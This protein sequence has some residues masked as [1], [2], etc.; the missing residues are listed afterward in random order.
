MIRTS[1]LWVTALFSLCLFLSCQADALP[2]EQEAVKTDETTITITVHPNK[3]PEAQFEI[4]PNDPQARVVNTELT[5]DAS[6]LS[7]G[8]YFYRLDAGN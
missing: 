7:S 8:V 4:I 5:F 6:R 1:S 2:Q 3:V